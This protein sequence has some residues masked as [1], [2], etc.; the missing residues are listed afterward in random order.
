MGEKIAPFTN[1]KNLKRLTL[2]KY[3]KLYYSE[4]T[5]EEMV[6]KFGTILIRNHETDLFKEFFFS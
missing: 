6:I 2:P 1:I 4:K 3:A 5:Y